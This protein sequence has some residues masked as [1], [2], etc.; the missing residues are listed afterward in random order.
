MQR[1]GDC[2]DDRRARATAVHL[3]RQRITNL[4]GPVGQLHGRML[5]KPFLLWCWDLVDEDSLPVMLGL[6]FATDLG[7]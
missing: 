3:S 5:I 1:K 7:T 2:V 6:G 4:Q